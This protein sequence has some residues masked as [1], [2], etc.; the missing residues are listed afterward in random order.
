MAK[1]VFFKNLPKFEEVGKPEPLRMEHFYFP[2]G[3]WFAGTMIS[4]LCF[5]A[6]IIT[7]RLTRSKNVPILTVEEPEV[8][9]DVGSDNRDVENVE[10][11][12]V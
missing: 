12:D 10:D 11:T 9:Q 5:L 4:L 8:T 2:F 6:E 1:E 3:L 7:Q